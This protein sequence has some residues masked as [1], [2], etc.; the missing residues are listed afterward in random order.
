MRLANRALLEMRIGCC[1]TGCQIGRFGDNGTHHAIALIAII[2]HARGVIDAIK[3]A[4]AIGARVY[5][6]EQMRGGNGC[7]D[8]RP[9]VADMVKAN[10]LESCEMLFGQ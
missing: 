6:S 3:P 10:P 5:F 9:G 8:L 7:G 4:G 2:K 1:D